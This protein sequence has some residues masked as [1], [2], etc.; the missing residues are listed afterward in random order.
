MFWS[1]SVVAMFLCSVICAGILI[2]QILLIAFRKSLFDVPDERKI[3]HSK[4]PRLGGMTF[5]PVVLF[6]T[7]LLLGVTLAMGN[8]MFLKE[9]LL[10][11][12]AVAFLICAVIM[13]YLVGLA[14]DLVGVR[15]R[16][17]FIVQILCAVMFIAAGVYVH[18]F[19]GVIFLNELYSWFGMMFTML[20]V[21]FVINAINLID[22]VDGLASG[23]S[24]VA[25]FFYGTMFYIMSE[26]VCA[27][28]AF[29]TLGAVIQFFYYN[30]FG[31]AEKQQKIFMGDTGALT[32]GILLC[33]LAL[34]L[35]S[36]GMKDVDG[37]NPLV[38]AFAPLMVPCFDVIRVFLGRIRRRSNPFMPDKTHIHHKLMLVGMTPRLTMITII[39]CSVIF[40]GVNIILSP[41]LNVNILLLSDI[42]VWVSFNM[43]LTRK[44]RCRSN[45]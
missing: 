29:A 22:G 23:L 7:S 26:Y 28:I 27:L 45:G 8:V 37:I 33:F 31:K 24:G 20:L 40:A 39:L 42:V 32:I 25:L 17:K 35:C 15:Y 43:W 11:I 38:M 19:C 3:H 1:L 41:Y 34:K 6:S 36:H 21:V 4:V 13:L 9:L 2:P 14:D 10:D 30:V 16:A 18:D 12:K 5:A 44:I